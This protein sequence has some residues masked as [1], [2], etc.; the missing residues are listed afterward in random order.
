MS[1]TV[2]SNGWYEEIEAKAKKWWKEA[3]ALAKSC[4]KPTNKEVMR[5]A[6]T[7]GWGCFA[8]GLFGAVIELMFI[9]VVRVLTGVSV[10]NRALHR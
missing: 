6:K 2:N 10:E 5:M 1:V 7:I 8:I 4:T 9:P 3:S